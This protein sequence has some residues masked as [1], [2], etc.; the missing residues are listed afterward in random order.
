MDIEKWYKNEVE[1]NRED[2]PEA[3]WSSIQ[4]DLDLEKVWTRLD[5]S[6]AQTRKFPIWSYRAAAAGIA[7]LLGFSSWFFWFSQK[8]GS[9]I[10]PATLGQQEQVVE[11]LDIV[12]AEAS[13]EPQT[14]ALQRDPAPSQSQLDKGNL[15]V[16]LA[17]EGTINEDIPDAL[18][19]VD[20]T[21]F[22]K[23]ELTP[24]NKQLSD[25]LSPSQTLEQEFLASLEPEPLDRSF[26]I[27][28]LGQ[29]ANTW[30]LSPKTL[31]GLQSQELTATNA[32]FGKNFGLTLMKPLSNRASLK[33]DLMVLSESR[34]NYKEYLSGQYLTTSL[35]LD[36]SSLSLMLSVRPGKAGSPHYIHLGGYAGT[37]IQ[38]REVA[39][40][41][42]LI[43]RD[44]YSN[45]DFGL[46]GGYE[47]FIPVSDNIFLGTGLYAKYGLTNAFSG[48]QQIP[49]YLNRTHNAAFIFS[50]SINYEIN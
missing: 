48:N 16:D 14:I 12:P 34:Q 19:L 35:Q 40:Q 7:L 37:L 13:I 30:L 11:T 33:A 5:N 15:I 43:V 39:G 21:P 9:T 25:I 44:E 50:L 8:E 18:K 49:E 29:F 17:S 23:Q 42:N 27:G 3:L 38:A 32:S 6:L 4:D 45:T 31:R 36:Y 46:V 41:N 10:A 24:P 2:P 26:S 28:I 47:Y 1:S 20:L 22:D